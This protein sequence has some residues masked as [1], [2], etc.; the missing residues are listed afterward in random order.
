MPGQHLPPDHSKGDDTT[1]GGYAAVHAR[2][3]AL[4]GRDGMSYSIEILTDATGDPGRPMGAFLLFVQ[5]KRIGEQGVQGHFESEFL[6]FGE[7]APQVRR[8]LGEWPLAEVQRVLDALIAN[9]TGAEQPR[10][11]W[12]VMRDEGEDT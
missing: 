1:V 4:E 9:R 10:R 11:W 12:D 6:V 3:A 7:T 2:P 5:W 8:A